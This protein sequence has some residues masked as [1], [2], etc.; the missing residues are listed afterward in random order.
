M[1]KAILIC[2]VLTLLL[3]CV[4]CGGGPKPYYETAEG[5]KKWQHYNKA[6]YGLLNK[7][8]YSKKK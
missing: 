4:A 5:K 8:G 6:Q 3:T 7:T 1:K 2:A